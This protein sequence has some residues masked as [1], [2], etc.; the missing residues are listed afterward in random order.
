MFYSRYSLETDKS[1]DDIGVTDVFT[2]RVLVVK[3]LSTTYLFR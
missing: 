2:D 1:G 3:Y